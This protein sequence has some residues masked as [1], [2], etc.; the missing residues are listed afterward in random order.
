MAFS[1]T[2][3]SEEIAYILMN[4]EQYVRKPFCCTSVY[5]CSALPMQQCTVP[6]A[7]YNSTG[8]NRQDSK[9]PPGLAPVVKGYEG[10][11]YYG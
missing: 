9:I 7:V 10:I 4:I 6:P 2:S 5:N 8:M 3:L 1:T 11:H